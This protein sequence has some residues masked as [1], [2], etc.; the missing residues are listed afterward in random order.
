MFRLNKIRLNL[1]TEQI[2]TIDNLEYENNSGNFD[3]VRNT[4]VCKTARNSTKNIDGKKASNHFKLKPEV[5]ALE[6]NS[7]PNLK[8]D[9]S[10]A[11]T[12]Q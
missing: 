11:E 8:L 3:E 12:S 10:T 4:K 2:L 1:D 9:I 6:I 5:N 7:K